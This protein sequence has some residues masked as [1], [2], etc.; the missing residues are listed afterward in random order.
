[1]NLTKSSWGASES[2]KSAV[3]V[4]SAYLLGQVTNMSTLHCVVDLEVTMLLLIQD[5]DVSFQPPGSVSQRCV[6]VVADIR[7][8]QAAIPVAAFLSLLS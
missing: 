2:M 3:T 7:F 4:V 1:M 6:Y 5:P 8:L